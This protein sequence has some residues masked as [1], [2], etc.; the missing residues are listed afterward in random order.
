LRRLAD[1][2]IT[3]SQQ[4]N[5]FTSRH[6]DDTCVELVEKLLKLE[7][8]KPVHQQNWDDVLATLAEIETFAL[9]IGSD[10]LESCAVGGKILVVA[11]HKRDVTSALTLG[12][13]Y[14]ARPTL[15]PNQRFVIK[16]ALGRALRFAN[17]NDLAVSWLDAALREDTEDFSLEKLALRSTP[18]LRQATRIIGKQ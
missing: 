1:I 14:L 2:H 17:R 3:L 9:R 12:E 11:E 13:S 10:L 8:K 4:R 18:R 15:T 16:D 5:L 6:A 7:L